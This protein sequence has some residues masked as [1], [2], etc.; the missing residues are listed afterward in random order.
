MNMEQNKRMYSTI[1]Q[2][3]NRLF[4][5]NEVLTIPLLLEEIKKMK[6]E[7]FVMFVPIGG[8]NGGR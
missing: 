6:E 3:E 4:E 2:N 8:V 7:E 5:T 1:Q